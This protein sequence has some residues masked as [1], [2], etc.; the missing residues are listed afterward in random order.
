VRCAK[1]KV[2]E[3]CGLAKRSGANGS[4]IIFGVILKIDLVVKII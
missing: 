1:A 4:F 2:A 3:G